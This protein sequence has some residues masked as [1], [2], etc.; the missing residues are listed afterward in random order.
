MHFDR[1]FTVK[2]KYDTILFDLDGTLTD[3]SPGIINSIKYALNELGKEIPDEA[4]FQKFLGPPLIYSFK[5]FCGFDE[6][7]ANRAVKL[8]RQRYDKYCDIENALYDGI[9]DTLERLRSAGKRLIVATSKP[10]IYAKRIVSHF[11]L[12]RYFDAVCGATL[13]ESRN[14]K[15]MVIKYAIESCNVTDLEHTLMV[16][17]RKHDIEGAANVG[18]DSMGVLYGYGDLSELKTAGA[19]YIAASVSEIADIILL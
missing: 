6:E 8:Y 18:I 13:D 1:G 5:N 12:D 14:T 9:C 2:K 16:G 4:V 11:G 7:L 10:D 17:D 19:N 3:S 15:T